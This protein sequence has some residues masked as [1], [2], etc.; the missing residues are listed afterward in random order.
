VFS[1]IPA[2][3]SP[4][5]FAGVRATLFLL[6]LVPLTNL[7]LL[8]MTGGL[9]A[10]PVEHVLRSLGTWTLISLLTTLAVTPLRWLTGWAWLVRLRR[11]LGLY[12]FFYGTLHVLAYVWIDHF[13]DWVAIVDDIVKR[14]YLTFG[15]FAYMLMIPLAATSTNGMVRRLGGRNWQRLH[16]LVYAIG[17][18]GV[19]HYW[20]HKLAKNDLAEP[21]IYALVLGGLL[22]VRLLRAAARRHAPVDAAPLR[23]RPQGRQDSPA[24][25]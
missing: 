16:R 18:L 11:M 1:F 10:N 17:V 14:P 25:N 22:G 12:A 20:Y 23:P 9:G 8:G 5:T 4:R 13:F 2:A 3:L 7:V 19:L 21:T 6:A 15:F 24:N